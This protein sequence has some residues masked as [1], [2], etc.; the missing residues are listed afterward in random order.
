MSKKR[1][2]VEATSSKKRTCL[3]T[4]VDSTC[5]GHPYGVK[6]WGNYML[7]GDGSNIRESSLG[8]LRILKDEN[9]LVILSLVSAKDLC[10]LAQSSKVLYV[11]SH[12]SDLWRDLTLKHIGGEFTYTGHWKVP[13]RPQII[14]F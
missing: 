1:A 4:G 3:D 8:K 10:H 6:P 14:I 2:A 5:S 7:D 13:Q 11:F 9:L 12:H